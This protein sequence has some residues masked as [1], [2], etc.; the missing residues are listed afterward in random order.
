MVEPPL[1][2]GVIKIW[3]SL[4]LITDVEIDGESGIEVVDT[5][6]VWFI[7]GLAKRIW[8]IFII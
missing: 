1:Y 3:I 7:V 8:I 2:E 6:L 5:I 4:K